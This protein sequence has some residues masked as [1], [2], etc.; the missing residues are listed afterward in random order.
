MSGRVLII[1][2]QRTGNKKKYIA[3]DPYQIINKR[4]F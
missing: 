2:E 4:G 1:F 3:L